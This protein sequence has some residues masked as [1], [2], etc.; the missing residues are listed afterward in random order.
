M[1]TWPQQLRKHAGSEILAA[2]KADTCNVEFL[3]NRDLDE[4]FD[5]IIAAAGFQ[6]ALEDC[7][8][9]WN[10]ADVATDS[11]DFSDTVPFKGRDVVAFRT[12]RKQFVR[13]PRAGGGVICGD[14]GR[15]G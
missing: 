4:I 15:R 12:K 1:V 2:S 7:E 14:G 11:M 9:R 10:I 3:S 13:P 6:Q 5:G 8:C